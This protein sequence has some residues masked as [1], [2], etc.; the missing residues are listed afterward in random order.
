MENKTDTR[1]PYTYACDLI[2][3][4]AGYR[5]GGFG[6]KLSRLDASLIRELF[7]KVTGLADEHLAEK[8]ADY[9]KANEEEITDT[10]VKEFLQSK[11]RNPNY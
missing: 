5:D 3:S 10:S 6:T 2:R 4:V 8:L 7:S 9:Y 1:Y 11:Q